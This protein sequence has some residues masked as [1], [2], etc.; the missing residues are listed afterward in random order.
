[1]PGKT[2]AATS[3]SGLPRRSLADRLGRGRDA[4]RNDVWIADLAA[5]GTDPDLPSPAAP[6]F[7]PLAVGLDAQ[8]GAYV[9]RDG[10]LYVATVWRPEGPAGVTDPSTPEPENWRD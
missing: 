2:R 6:R 9:G 10:R 4:P 8:V 7:R 5:D 3:A 1:V